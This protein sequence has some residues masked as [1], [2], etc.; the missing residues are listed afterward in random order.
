MNRRK[1]K[2]GNASRGA[3]IAANKHARK[4]ERKSLIQRLLDVRSSRRARRGECVSC[5]MPLTDA[6]KKESKVC[7]ECRKKKVSK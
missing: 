4:A 3:R 1:I 6:E 2:K 7:E 5:G